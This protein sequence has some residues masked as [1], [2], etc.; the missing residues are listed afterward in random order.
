[1]L[2][3]VI[4]K[5]G[6]TPVDL[7]CYITNYIMDE[8]IKQELLDLYINNPKGWRAVLKSKT[9]NYLVTALNKEFPEKLSLSEKMFW[10]AN[11]LKTFPKCPVC[12]LDIHSFGGQ[13]KGYNIFCSC[14]CAQKSVETRQKLKNTNMK[15][16]G[17]ENPAQSKI[18]QDKIKQTCLA[19]YGAENVYASEFGKQKIK[20][21]MLKKYGVENCQQSKTIKEKTKKTLVERYNI[22][23]GFHRNKNYHK[24]KGEIELFN[25]IKELI[26][27]AKHSDRKAIWPLELDIYIESLKIGIEYDG[28]YWHSLPEMVKRD[29][30]KDEIC[31]QR[32]IRLIRIKESDW[33]SNKDNIKQML[34]ELF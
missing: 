19:K 10:L 34:K 7:L 16:Y 23:C 8:K 9:K 24:S 28:G 15:L 25:F 4:R 30:K 27:S 1:M 32:G 18:V 33:L 3:K 6:F 12:G 20:A 26:P 31:Q 29:H 5:E 2:S 13:T 11:N 21:T 22:T 14:S 17:V